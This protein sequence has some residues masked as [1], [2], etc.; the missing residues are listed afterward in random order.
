MNQHFALP[1]EVPSFLR[2]AEAPLAT[3]APPVEEPPHVD[4]LKFEAE[5]ARRRLDD[6]A[7]VVRA[8]TYGEMIEFAK[9][10][11]E[12]RPNEVLPLTEENLPGVL[13]RMAMGRR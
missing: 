4:I 8:L 9:A 10:I 11:W 12:A 1:K 2:R 7:E 13:H 6:I 3:T 5:L